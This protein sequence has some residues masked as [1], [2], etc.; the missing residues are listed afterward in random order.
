MDTPR[1]QQQQVSAAAATAP[2]N[3]LRPTG[4]A[5]TMNTPHGVAHPSSVESPP[6]AHTH[7]HTGTNHTESSLDDETFEMASALANAFYAREEDA[8]CR[9]ALLD[10][11]EAH[12]WLANNNNPSAAMAGAPVSQHLDYSQ[13]QALQQQQQQLYYAQQQQ[14][15]FYLQQHHHLQQQ[16]HAHHHHQQQQHHQQQHHH[17]QQ[18]PEQAPGS[19]DYGSLLMLS[20]SPR[21]SPEEGDS[22]LMN[23]AFIAA[24]GAPTPSSAPT[25]GAAAGAE[26]QTFREVRQIAR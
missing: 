9:K 20:H 26:Q 12:P 18:A 17:Q 14:Q 4:A 21:N 2:N 16:H 24:G 5:M 13:Q 11:L 8:A 22:E 6:G 10:A 23:Q 15:Q 25:P 1:S 3:L 19:W 7:A